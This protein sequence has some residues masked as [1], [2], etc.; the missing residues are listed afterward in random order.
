MQHYYGDMQLIYVN[1]QDNHVYMQHNLSG[2]LT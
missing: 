2:M 1:M